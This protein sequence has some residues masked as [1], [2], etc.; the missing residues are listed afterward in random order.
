MNFNLSKIEF[1]INIFKR[2]KKK[3]Y[4]VFSINIILTLQFRIEKRKIFEIKINEK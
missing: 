2:N 4:F 1:I 3:T